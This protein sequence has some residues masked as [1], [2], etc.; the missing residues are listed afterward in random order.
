MDDQLVNGF[1][2]WS[3]HGDSMG[4]CGCSGEVENTGGRALMTPDVSENGYQGKQVDK[5]R[6]ND[7]TATSSS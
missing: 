3:K 4:C 5:I 7:C 2:L 6:S 1:V